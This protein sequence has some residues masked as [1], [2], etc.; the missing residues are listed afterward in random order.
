MADVVRVL[1]VDDESLVRAGLRLLLDGAHG[2]RVIGEA[3]DGREALDVATRL[4]P[5]VVLMDFR[6]PG[7]DGI[8]GIALLRE[9]DPAPAVLMLTAFDTEADILGAFE[10]GARGFLLKTA[11]PQTLSVAV[12]DA[13]AGR[14]P[15]TAEVLETLVT[16]ASRSTPRATHDLTQLSDREC[17]IAG[18]VA[19]GLSNEEIAGRIHLAVPTVKTHVSRVMGKLGAKNRVQIA[20]AYLTAG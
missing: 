14:P 20:V 16:M 11:K 10:A 9:L 3:A 13:A 6:M 15:V 4:R 18:L 8:R 17:E 7:T 1:L 2:I 19:E 12:L 5:D